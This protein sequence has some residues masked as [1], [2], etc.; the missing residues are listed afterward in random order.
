LSC[1]KISFEERVLPLKPKF[2]AYSHDTKEKTEAYKG[3]E[4]YPR[5]ENQLQSQEQ[6][7]P[8]DSRS[9]EYSSTEPGLQKRA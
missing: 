8:L 1:F 5:W 3:E 6:T 4:A 7:W 9:N 2:K